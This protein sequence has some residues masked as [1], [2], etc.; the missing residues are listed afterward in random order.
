MKVV[1]FQ[2]CGQETQKI[3]CVLKQ[4]IRPVEESNMQ[5]ANK[6]ELAKKDNKSS[7]YVQ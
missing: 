6:K 4:V 1:C 5:S 2:E 7:V 3:I